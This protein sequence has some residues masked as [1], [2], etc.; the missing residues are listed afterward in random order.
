MKNWKVVANG[1]ENEVVFTPN[2]WTGKY[3]LTV[4]G[5]AVELK[6]RFFQSL[7]FFVALAYKY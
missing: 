3:K 5:E 6:P 7:K 2:R 1:Y 4:N